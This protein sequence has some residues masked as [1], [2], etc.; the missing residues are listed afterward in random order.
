MLLSG[1][2][3]GTAGVLTAGLV[4]S[5]LTAGSPAGFSSGFV[6]AAGLVASAGAP[7][8]DLTAARGVGVGAAASG[9]VSPLLSGAFGAATGA[10]RSPGSAVIAPVAPNTARH[11][12]LSITTPSS[13]KHPM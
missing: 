11:E 5:G 3:R 1:P 6:A 9:G 13:V 12:T 10:T 2:V 7:P 4:A 8:S